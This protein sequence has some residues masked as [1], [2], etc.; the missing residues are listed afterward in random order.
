MVK[1]H[2]IVINSD[3]QNEICQI[4]KLNRHCWTHFSEYPSNFPSI[5][6]PKILNLPNFF[7][8]SPVYM[9]GKNQNIYREMRNRSNDVLNLEIFSKF[10]QTVLDKLSEYHNKPYCHLEGTSLPGFHIFN[11]LG[12]SK[13]FSWGMMHIDSN[14][15]SLE[16][17]ANYDLDKIWSFAVFLETTDAG[18][19]LEYEVGS[20]KFKHHY[21]RG[22]LYTWPGK[23]PH[24]IG[25]VILSTDSQY[26]ISLQGHYYENDHILEYY[27]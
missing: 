27:W 21:D 25:D 8:G 15:K 3:L 18:D 2:G 19:Y 5:L 20:K 17:Y 6:Q 11:S 23:T 4:I 12:K 14:I 9:V 10:R 26:R 1:N 24:R 13:K 16:T 22:V 7:L